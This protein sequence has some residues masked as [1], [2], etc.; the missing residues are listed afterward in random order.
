MSKNT[1]LQFSGEI[2]LGILKSFALFTISALVGQG[3]KLSNKDLGEN[4]LKGGRYIKN[5]YL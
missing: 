2:T 4:L 5:K 3:I 1:I